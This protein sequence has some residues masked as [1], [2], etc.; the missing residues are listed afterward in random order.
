MTEALLASHIMDNKLRSQAIS[1]SPLAKTYRHKFENS[2]HFQSVKA[3]SAIE[4]DT[5]PT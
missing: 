1:K 4:F 3:S 2:Q 5:D